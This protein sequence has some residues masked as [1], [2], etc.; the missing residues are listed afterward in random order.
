MQEQNEWIHRPAC[1]RQPIWHAL[2]LTPNST[3]VDTHTPLPAQL[4]PPEC[5]WRNLLTRTI[6]SSSHFCLLGQFFLDFHPVCRWATIN[7]VQ[8]ELLV[9]AEAGLFTVRMDSCHLKGKGNVFYMAIGLDWAGFNVSTNSTGY[10]GD[11][12]TGQKTQP[13]ASKYWRKSWPAT[14]RK[15]LQSS[16]PTR[17]SHRVT[18]GDFICTYT[19]SEYICDIYVDGLRIISVKLNFETRRNFVSHYLF[20]A[21]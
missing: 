3:Q 11:S 19:L 17:G 5:E 6:T 7:C 14:D 4:H 8:S 12:F 15:R 2:F 10:P 1:D 20:T 9:V 21:N 13:T 18:S 16:K